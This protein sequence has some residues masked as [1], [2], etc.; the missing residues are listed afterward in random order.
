LL[1]IRP[2]CDSAPSMLRPHFLD[3]ESRRD[4]IELTSD[5]SVAHRLARRANALVLLDDGMSC[6]AIAKVLFLDDDTIRTW[7][8]LYQQ[9]GIEGL[10]GFGHE[11]GVCRLTADQ[12]DKLKAWIDKTLPRTTRE[13][14]AWIAV[15]CG[16]DYQTRSGLI[17]LLH[18]L[19]VEHRKPKAI[20]RKL[21][22]ARQEAFIKAYEGLLNQLSA[23]EAALRGC[24]ASN[25]RGSPGWLL[26]T[27]RDAR[28]DPAEQWAEPLEYS[29]RHRS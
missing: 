18:R 27:E 16:I 7:Y 21:D 17:A 29:W 20:S 4:L 5:G 19:G 8:Q 28:R 15:E 11:G 25:P 14:G 24:G 12:Q 23:D 13:V 9:D 10:A 1:A 6:A 26:G 3:P 22:P 2:R